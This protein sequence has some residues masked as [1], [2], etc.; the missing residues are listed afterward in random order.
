MIIPRI[1]LTRVISCNKGHITEDIVEPIK[2][3]LSGYITPKSPR[4]LVMPDITPSNTRG[5]FLYGERC[6]CESGRNHSSLTYG[7]TCTCRCISDTFTFWLGDKMTAAS[8]RRRQ[9]RTSL[10]IRGILFE[11]PCP[12]HLYPRCFRCRVNHSKLEWVTR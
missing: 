2:L 8:L 12:G 3:M 11:F 9:G 6:S 10:P 7:S 5:P 1:P 4:T